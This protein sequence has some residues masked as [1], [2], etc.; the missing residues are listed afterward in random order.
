MGADMK[1]IWKDIQGFEGKYQISNFARVKSLSRAIKKTNGTIMTIKERIL[2]TCYNPN[3]YEH[4]VLQNG[5]KTK[6]LSVHRLVALA[7]IPNP[8]N[9]PHINHKDGNKANNQIENLEWVTRSE[10]EKHAHK[11]GLKDWRGEKASK[12]KLTKEQVLDIR[13]LEGKKTG[14]EVAKLY[15]VNHSCIFA[16]WKRRTWS[17]V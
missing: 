15:N 8:N 11:I 1:E 12:S 6:H 2:K 17:H 14:R 5:K 16:I 3:G 13:N 9:K 7:F 4:A 10:N